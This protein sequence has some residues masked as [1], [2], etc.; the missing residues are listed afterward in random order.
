MP[1]R[2]IS[3][4]KNVFTLISSY[5]E[6]PAE[7]SGRLIYSAMG[8][9]D[10]PAVGDWIEFSPV[11]DFTRGIV[12]RILPRKTSLKRKAVGKATDS[13]VIAANIDMVFI[14]QGLDGNFNPRRLER[15][16]IAVKASGANPVVLLSKSDICTPEEI[17]TFIS[18]AKEVVKDADIFVYSSHDAVSMESIGDLIE[19]GVS[20]CF[21]G[22]SGVGKSTLIN[23][24]SGSNLE[25]AEVREWDSRGRHTTSQKNLIFLKNGGMVI[26]TPGMRE[27]GLLDTSEGIGSTFPEISSLADGCRFKDCTH[28]SE[29][30]CAVIN[31][32]ESGEI[33]QK[34]YES[35]LALMRETEY[36]RAKMNEGT[37][38]AQK[39]RQKYYNRVLRETNKFKKR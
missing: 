22:S 6:I 17:E 11:D 32:I 27:I 12:H 16:I 34:R 36:M 5:G 8:R 10:L 35:Y 30:D 21:V 2:V 20:A 38:A 31:A 3:E 28:T 26:D 33:E 37:R 15:Y 13:Q 9:E 24:L 7:A 39:R 18:R 4:S 29:P 25:T 19:K 14:V 23:K 1:G